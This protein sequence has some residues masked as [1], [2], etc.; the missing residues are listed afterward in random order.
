MKS[1]KNFMV[2]LLL[3]LFL[4]PLG[5]HRFYIEKL[6]TGVMMLLMTVTVVFFPFAI[7]WAVI[8]FIVLLTGG[9]TDKKGFT[10]KQ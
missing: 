3:C 1:E 2:V 5:I 9:L 4:G 6:G 8:D 7:I 10:I